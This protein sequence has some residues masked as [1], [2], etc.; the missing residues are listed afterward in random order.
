MRAIP[1]EAESGQDTIY[2][3]PAAG[4][5]HK[6][7]LGKLIHNHI[8][9]PNITTIDYDQEFLGIKPMAYYPLEGKI[10]RTID[11]EL[12]DP[13][14]YSL[15]D[16]TLVPQQLT[17][18]VGNA[19]HIHTKE[20]V[21]KNLLLIHV[22]QPFDSLLFKESVRLIRSQKYVQDVMAYPSLASPK[23]DSIDIH[24]RVIDI[25]SIIPSWSK[26][27]QSYQAGLAD[28][29]FLGTGNRLQLDPRFGKNING[30]VSQLGYILSNIGDSHITGSFQYYFLGNNDLINNQDIR[31]PVYSSLSYN[32]PTLSLSNRYL[33]RSI[34]L[35]RPF[36]S[37]LA[38]WAG[39]IFLGQLATRQ[40]YI[41]KDSVRY[42]SSKTSI[43]D[44]WGAVSLP[45]PTI[46]SQA[47]RTSGIIISARILRTRYPKVLAVSETT[48]LFNNENFYLAGIGIAS[49]RYIQDRY[50]FNYGKIEDIPVGRSFGITTGVLRQKNDQF[51]LGLK[52][53]WGDN[54]AF[55]YLSTL[56]EY[57]T[58]I[59]T[60]GFRQQVISARINYYTRLFNAGY[61]RIRQFIKPTVIVGINRLPTDNLS[62]GDAMKGF[63]ELKNPATRMMALT[64]QT[65]S[66][67]PWEIYG[68]RLGPYIFSSFGLL[69]NHDNISSGNRFYSALG[70]GVLIKNN[71]LLIN[72][73]QV[74]FTFYPFLPERGY[75]V[76]NLNAYKTTDYGLADFEISK[77]QVVEYK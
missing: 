25:W 42:I 5:A 72:T 15:Q 29:N 67:S 64:L 73:F 46:Y 6:T 68:F 71:Y 9:S 75:N 51:Y 35:Y 61:W 49:R 39:G 40:N 34:E 74:S 21:I 7:I 59:G 58:F 14:G 4:P 65:Q 16:T 8:L 23:A 48:S 31:K 12:L 54:Y 26:T 18:K 1:H 56:M 27:G 69:S 53:V 44:V 33:I 63:D 76:F 20:K 28:N 30:S 45:L 41:D 55:G 38:R 32:L 43:Q 47:S 52:A 36:F 60:N 10:I 13:F 62:L 19:L 2:R 50:V 3:P 57:G 66:Y 24:I 37:P 11:I 17:K 77:P 22:H 70:L